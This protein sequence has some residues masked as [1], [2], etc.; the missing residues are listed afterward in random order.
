MVFGAAK[1][2]LFNEVSSL[3]GVLIT[4][5]HYVVVIH[6]YSLDVVLKRCSRSYIMN[7]NAGKV[8]F[9]HLRVMYGKHVASVANFTTK[10]PVYTEAFLLSKVYIYDMYSCCT[11]Q[12]IIPCNHIPLPPVMVGISCPSPPPPACW[13]LC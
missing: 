11:R 10:A 7:I 5:I 4:C 3:Q 8:I 12:Q 6:E 13:L 2:V 1:A 9:S